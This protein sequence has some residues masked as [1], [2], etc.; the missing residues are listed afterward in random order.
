MATKVAYKT[1]VCMEYERLLSTCVNALEKWR[2]R[3]EE[4][5][6]RHLNGRAVGDELMRLQADYAKA[7]WQLER[8]NDNCELCRFVARIGRQTMASVST[9]VMERKNSA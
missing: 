3:R 8:H 5:S 6:N 9:A 2:N 7:Y 4:L 1:A